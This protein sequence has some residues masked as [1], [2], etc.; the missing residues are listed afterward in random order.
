METFKERLL[1]EYLDLGAK[2]KRL[3][4]FLKTDA[5]KRLPSNQQLAIDQQRVFMKGYYNLL[6]YRI[7]TSFNHDEKTE[8]I[9][10]PIKKIL[11]KVKYK[12]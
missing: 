8:L 12:E 4:T 11:N 5:F 6:N 2:I 9:N 3:Q 10:M 7:K 1:E